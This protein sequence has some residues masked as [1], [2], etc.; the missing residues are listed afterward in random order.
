M[1]TM[2]AT[3]DADE[4]DKADEELRETIRKLWPL[5]S[6][7]KINLLVPLKEGKPFRRGQGH[8]QERQRSKVCLIAF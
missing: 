3:K 7:K 6:A 5:Q 8:V 4:M 1:F 2:F